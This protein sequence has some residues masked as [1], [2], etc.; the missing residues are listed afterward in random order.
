MPSPIQ[1]IE[2]RLTS[3]EEK[4]DQ[5][6]NQPAVPPEVNLSGLTALL[7]EIHLIVTQINSN[8][9][10]SNQVTPEQQAQQAMAVLQQIQAQLQQ[11]LQSMP[12][13][14]NPEPI[15]EPIPEPEPLPL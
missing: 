8:T 6:L 11:Q 12:N 2:T 5:I 4:I 1:N 9:T 10:P 14:I 7:G 3:I 13:Q 15:P